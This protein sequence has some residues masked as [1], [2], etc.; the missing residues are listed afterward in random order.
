[1]NGV[2]IDAGDGGDVLDLPELVGREEE[3]GWYDETSKS[4]VD[5]R[6]VTVFDDGAGIPVGVVDSIRTAIALLAVT[7]L[8]SRCQHQQPEAGRGCDVIGVTPVRKSQTSCDARDQQPGTRLGGEDG[9]SVDGAS[10][11]MLG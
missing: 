9:N 4:V 1:V 5:G 8:I 11:C 10:R 7:N 6:T 3:G 2:G